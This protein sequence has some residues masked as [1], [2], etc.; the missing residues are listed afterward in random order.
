MIDDVKRVH[1]EL[2]DMRAILVVGDIAGRGGVADYQIAAS[3]LDSLCDIVGC[4][5]DQVVCVPG[6]HDI[7]RAAHGPLHKAVRHQ[8][9]TIPAPE[10]S[11]TLRD[12][13]ADDSGAQV[14]LEPLRN[15]N[16]FALGYGCDISPG[17]IVWSPKTLKLDGRD[18]YIHGVT[19]P[20]I[21]NNDDG[22]E[23]DEKK[24]VVGLFQ[25]RYIGADSDGIHVAL[26][27]HPMRWLRD[28]D[29]V[30]T[31]ARVAH[32]YLTGHEHEAGIIVAPDRRS[33]HIASGAVNPNRTEAAGWIPAY[34]VI[35]LAVS[36]G[37]PSELE[38]RV[39]VQTWQAAQGRAEF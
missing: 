9:R 30:S 31:W 2:G 34:N 22:H 4:E 21:S 10:L 19:S 12:L 17:K 29:Q 25:Y 18:L 38:V 3:F 11:D 8:L 28:S 5:R 35:E 24:L 32:V 1:K 14:L 26:C 6:N 7:N 33:M 13:L 20:W 39:H 15:Y 27:H 36:D 23:E 37:D 16:N